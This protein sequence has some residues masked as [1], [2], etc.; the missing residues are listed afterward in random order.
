MRLYA[1][2][3]LMEKPIN[4][5]INFAD[6]LRSLPDP[7]TEAEKFRGLFDN[8]THKKV[9]KIVNMVVSEVRISQ[10]FNLYIDSKLIEKEESFFLTL[11]NTLEKAGGIS[12]EQE[13]N[14]AWKLGSQSI[15]KCFEKEEKS[16][17]REFKK[18]NDS[19]SANRYGCHLQAALSRILHWMS[20]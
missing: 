4:N 12:S 20:K 11:V 1:K 14:V 15:Y 2:I 19:G 7:K 9:E 6:N 5:Q 16:Y 17:F 8:L 10:Q 3:R 18:N 13:W